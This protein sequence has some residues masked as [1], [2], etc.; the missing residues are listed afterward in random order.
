MSDALKQLQLDF[1]AAIHQNESAQSAFI[2]KIISTEDFSAEQRFAVYRDSIRSAFLNTLEAVYPVCLRLVGPDY[3]AAMANIYCQ[4][5]ISHSPDLNDFGADFADFIASFEPARSLAYLADVARLEWA[6]HR[7]KL[8]PDAAAILPTQLRELDADRFEQTV[9]RRIPHGSLLASAFPLDR[10]WQVNQLEADTEEVDL[11]DGPIF[12]FVCY[13]QQTRCQ[14]ITAEQY[15]GLQLLD[16]Q[17][18]IGEIIRAHPDFAL[19]KVLAEL[20]QLGL[21]ETCA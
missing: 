12:L 20:L 21:L 2:A 9:F 4:N 11:S 10:I 17:H 14:R 16:G 7:S 1:L 13:Q 5:A 18:N 8:G 3:F 6:I 19:D 15:Q